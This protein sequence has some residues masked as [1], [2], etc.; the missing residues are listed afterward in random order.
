MADSFLFTNLNK[1]LH[2]RGLAK[3]ANSDYKLKY[4]TRFALANFIRINKNS[5]WLHCRLD[6]INFWIHGGLYRKLTA[7]TNEPQQWGAPKG[8]PGVGAYLR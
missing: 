7:A 8:P 6:V 1:F 3:S 4:I 2:T 5:S